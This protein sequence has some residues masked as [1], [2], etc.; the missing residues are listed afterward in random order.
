MVLLEVYMLIEE[1]DDIERGG[2]A[3]ECGLAVRWFAPA[4]PSVTAD[5]DDRGKG[6]VPPPPP[7]SPLLFP[8]PLSDVADRFARV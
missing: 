2:G 3:V 5:V 6:D 4:A 1:L 8:L 7:K